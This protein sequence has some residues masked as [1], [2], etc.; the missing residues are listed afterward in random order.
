M[1][2][3]LDDARMRRCVQRLREVQLRELLVEESRLLVVPELLTAHRGPQVVR[4]RQLHD[5]PGGSLRRGGSGV[6]AFIVYF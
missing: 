1:A 3:R 5:R 6:G 2:V 4:W